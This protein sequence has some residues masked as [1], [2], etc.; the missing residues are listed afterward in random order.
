MTK[1]IGTGEEMVH[2]LLKLVVIAAAL[3]SV[4][5]GA[6]ISIALDASTFPPEMKAE[7]EDVAAAYKEYPSEAAVL[8]QVAALHAR[9]GHK[10][11]ALEALRK[12]A[13]VGAG[14]DPRSRN[15]GDLSKDKEF[16]RI[17][18]EIQKA[19]PAVITA[20]LAYTIRE[21][22]LMPE[23]IAYSEK[24]RKL[25]LG[26]FRKIV[27]IA[28][29]GTYEPFVAPKTG[30]LGTVLGIRV[31]DQRGELWAVS[32]AINEKTPDM[33][34]GLFRFRL[35][36]GTL[37]KAYPIEDADKT[38][39]NDIAIG[40]DGSAYA[41]ASISGALW[42]VDPSG[43]IEKF[44]PDHSLPDPNGIVA[45]PDGK[46]LLVAGWYGITRVELKN[47]KTMLLEK[48]RNVADGCLDGMYLYNQIYIVGV[49]NCVHETGRIMR[50]KTAFD[51]SSITSAQ[52][53]ESYNPMFDGIT[54]AA[55]AGDQLYFQ[56]NTQFR[57]LGKPGEKFDPIKILRVSL[58]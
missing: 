27:S 3:T 23:G 19:N 55:I 8:Y 2:W 1:A 32:S 50:Y 16:L 40:K 42:R 52:V 26:S 9:A 48:P 17:K 29:D 6:K 20:R 31:D 44:L 18:G 5:Y 7:V 28:E 4:A 51:W 56:A 30:G 57:K 11:Q 53:L 15:F 34:L 33:V 54:T 36:D 25:Y 24:T 37:I 35:A 45:T 58:R 10:E 14:L 49:Q 12:M 43:K 41:T 21:G 22:D 39:V 46:Y 13:A 38:M 47:K